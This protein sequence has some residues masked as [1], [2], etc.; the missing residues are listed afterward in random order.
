MPDAVSGA[1]ERLTSFRVLFHSEGLDGVIVPRSD[2]YLGEYVPACAERLAWISEFTGSAG[3]AIILDTRAAVFSD[4]RYI[5]QM[6]EQIDGALWDRL[7]ITE[8]PPGNWLAA[9]APQDAK[10]GYDPKVIS[11]AVLDTLAAPDISLVPTTRNLID[12]IW[13]DRPSA[14][15]APAIV[16]SL[17]F[18][19]ENSKA[20]RAA[21]AERLIR[22]DQDAVVINDTTS[23]AWLLNIRGTDVPCTPVVLSSALLYRDARVDLFIASGK[24]TDEV[25]SWLGADVT[26]RLPDSLPE[27]LANLSGKT[28]VVDRA[29]TPVWFTQMLKT[30][31]A[32]VVEASD[33]CALPRAT[34]NLVEQEGAR[35]AH[36][37]DAVAVCKFLHWLETHAIGSTELDAAAQLKAFRS[38]APGFREE[39]FETISAAGPNGAIM[40]YRV[41]PKSNRSIGADTVYLVDS[42]GQYVDGTTD[43]T[44]TIWTGPGLPSKELQAAFTRVLK[45]NLRLGRAVFPV[46]IAGHA[47]DSLA[48]FSLW[49]ARLDFDH[50][51]GHGVGSY[52]SVHEGPQRISK[53]FSPVALAPGMILSNEPGYYRPGSFGIRLETLLLISEPETGPDGKQFLSFEI[54]TFAPFDKRL[55][56]PDIL[57]DEDAALLNSYHADVLAAVGPH[58]PHDVS[59]WLAH[60]CSPINRK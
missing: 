36:L 5:T 14:P 16:H 50:G 33:P 48:R 19:G 37:R 25:R 49:Q 31:G 18:A 9:H 26:V 42:G 22:E 27:T 54:L 53:A 51:T 8:T 15:M 46:G 2:E 59:S 30:S 44:R 40:H 60:A 43:I 58:L 23:V 4:G 24:I 57:G 20:K 1:A 34:K 3:L 6:D 35:K 29:N 21:L 56:D 32:T 11:Q 41:T 17:E 39:S 28:V 45:G 7:H 10:I 13:S 55:V 12:V 52:L 38:E 47:L